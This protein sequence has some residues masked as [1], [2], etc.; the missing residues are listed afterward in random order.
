[1]ITK[2]ID[3]SKL[4]KEIVFPDVRAVPDPKIKGLF[5][6]IKKFLF[7]RRQWIVISD[8][9]VWSDI[10]KS[11]I[12]VPEG[13]QF[14]GASVPKIFH[15]LLGPTGVLLLGA[16]PHDE[17]YKYGGLILVDH[18]DGGLTF[19]PMSKHILDNTFKDLCSKENSLGIVTYLSKLALTNFGFIAWNKY[20]KENRTLKEDF[21]QLY[22]E[23]N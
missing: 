15:S 2:V 23:R 7:H 19:V 12:F 21:P 8:Y 10:L 5:K 22:L 4:T 11:Y 13:F 18:F 6:R 16:C 9:I 17:G 1:M 14:D 20:R 3:R